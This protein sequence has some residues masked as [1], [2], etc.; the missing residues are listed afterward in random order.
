MTSPRFRLGVD[1]RPL[2][3]PLT[4]IGIAVRETLHALAVLAPEMEILCY[5][6]RGGDRVALELPPGSRA[7]VREGTGLA[8]R[9][10]TPWL[11]WGASGLLAA[12]RLDVF[13]G[14]N[15]VLPVGLRGRIPLVVTCND[16]VYRLHPQTL[17]RRDRL[18]LAP[19]ASR[20]LRAADRVIAISAATARD[21]LRFHPLDPAR[22]HVVPLAPG[23]E[24]RPL[25]PARAR[26]AVRDRFGIERDYV[27]FVGTREP[28]KN[29]PGFLRAMAEVASAFPGD[30]VVAGGT[31][32]GLA[33]PASLG[34]GHPLGERLRFLGYV[35]AADLPF[36]Y[37][38]ATLFVMP[39]F[40]EGF[41]LPVLEAMAAGV[42][43]VTTTGGALEE[44][45]G[46]AARLVPP[47]DDRAL[48]VAIADLLVDGPARTELRTRGLARAAS[49]SWEATAAGLL[50]VLEE[51]RRSWQPPPAS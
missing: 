47:G 36:L 30:A 10:G 42:P 45:S 12:D 15:L 9:F 44:V 6:A 25:D 33:D 39:S 4:G 5:T 48:A 3:T 34:R 43:V 16:L 11:H 17:S 2:A 41:G 40:Y 26:A 32:W 28:R 46:G 23:R 51:V 35:P 50:A 18:L 13:W 14:T 20:S 31:G 27:L 37:A 8:A 24:F 21:L 7:T 1:A 22:V 38:G 29:L 49:F 19:V